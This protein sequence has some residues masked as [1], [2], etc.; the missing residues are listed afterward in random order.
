M[1]ASGRNLIRTEAALISTRAAAVSTPV[2]KTAAGMAT[3]CLTTPT[4]GTTKPATST[5][6]WILFLRIP[7]Y[8]ALRT[9]PTAPTLMEDTTGVSAVTG[10]HQQHHHSHTARMVRTART[11][12]F[13]LRRP[14][15]AIGQLACLQGSNMSTPT[16]MRSTNTQAATTATSAQDAAQNFPAPASLWMSRTLTRFGHAWAGAWF[17]TCGTAKAGLSLLK[18][19]RH[20]STS[21]WMT[22]APLARV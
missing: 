6:L 4:V 5:C 2:I 11:S 18:G 20:G 7:S 13:R 12:H 15:L 17:T 19:E 22:V 21:S 9:M 16:W 1:T 8:Q 3:G 10:K 14:A